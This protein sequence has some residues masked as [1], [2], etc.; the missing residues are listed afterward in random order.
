M[1]VEELSNDPKAHRV[2]IVPPHFD[3]PQ[4]GKDV[5]ALQKA[6]NDRIKNN[7][8]IEIRRLKVDGRCGRD[9]VATTRQVARALGIGI[10]GVGLT[11]YLQKLVRDPAKRTAAQRARGKR[12]RAERMAD[13]EFKAEY[14]RQSRSITAIDEIVNRLDALRVDHEM[15]KAELEKAAK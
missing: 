13:P 12:Y 6:V 5:T 14:E 3:D 11:V 1:A 2:L 15:S 4:R 7:P 9:T 8:D 10:R